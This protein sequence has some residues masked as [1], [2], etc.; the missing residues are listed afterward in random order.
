MLRSLFSEICIRVAMKR[1][2]NRDREQE[3][4]ANGN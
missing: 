1:M 2:E 4:V 3:T